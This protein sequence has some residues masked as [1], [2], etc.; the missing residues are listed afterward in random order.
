MGSSNASTRYSKIVA[1]LE[2]L[3][4][5]YH[6]PVLYRIHI[7][8]FLYFRSFKFLKKMFNFI[9]YFLRDF[10]GYFASF[11]PKKYTYSL[12][13]KTINF[14]TLGKSLIFFVLRD[15]TGFLQA[16]LTDKLVS[17]FL[18]LLW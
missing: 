8:D 6:N 7:S 3:F 9:S 17:Y 5:G 12:L 16:V 14:F 4:F 13:I 11:F 10:L 18:L 15:G 2:L 1:I